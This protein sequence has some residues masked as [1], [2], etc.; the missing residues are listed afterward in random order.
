M[1]TSMDKP[2]ASG[3]SGVANGGVNR[4]D[5]IVT[6]FLQAIRTSKPKPKKSSLNDT[7]EETIELLRPEFDNRVQAIKLQFCVVA[8]PCCV[9]SCADQA[10]VDQICRV[11]IT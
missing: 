10:I 8:A 4:L 5:Y 11:N 2:A 6:Q 9:R 3:G 7:V 1:I